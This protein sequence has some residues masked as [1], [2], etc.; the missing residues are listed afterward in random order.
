MTQ[1]L[2]QISTLN[3][4]MDD[5]TSRIEEVNSNIPNRIA[6]AASGSLPSSSSQLRRESPQIEE[7][8]CFKIRNT[9]SI[10]F[11]NYRKHQR[12]VQTQIETM[13]GYKFM[14]L[15]KYFISLIIWTGCT[16]CWQ[17]TSD[18][19]SSGQTEQSSSSVCWRN[20]P[21]RE[22]QQQH[23]TE[24]CTF[25]CTCSSCFCHWM[26]RHSCLQ[27]QIAAVT[28]SYNSLLKLRVREKIVD[29]M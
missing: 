2:E 7:E 14:K 21:H 13:Y 17:T 24:P 15:E 26:Y 4:R 16:C 20:V 28:A 1:L 11:L 8:V 3:A 12:Q 9:C 19:A 25:H 5:F 27:S 6:A 29:M 10:L 18:N 23:N 22:R